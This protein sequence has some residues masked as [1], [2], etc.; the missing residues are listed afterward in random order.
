MQAKKSSIGD[1]SGEAEFAE[2]KEFSSCG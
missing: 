2:N 1:I